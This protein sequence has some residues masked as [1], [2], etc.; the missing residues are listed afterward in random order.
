MTKKENCCSHCGSK[1]I[2]GIS[3]IVGYFSKIQN[4]SPSK[5]EEL[6]ARQKGDYAVQREGGK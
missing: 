6:K 5:Q 3:R 4:W 1:S 2:E